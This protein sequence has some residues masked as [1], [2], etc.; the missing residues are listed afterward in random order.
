MVQSNVKWDI[1]REGLAKSPSG[2]EFLAEWRRFMKVHG[3]HCRGEVEF[4]NKRWSETPDYILGIL[5]G[6]INSTEKADLL[7]NRRRIAEQREQ[8]EKEC[9][10]R[11]KNPV[12]RAV[13]KHLLA[14]AQYG[15]V[16]R[17]NFKSE[18]I[19]LLASVRSILLELGQKLAARSLIA[20]SDDVFFLKLEELGQLAHSRTEE[21][22]IRQIIAARRADYEKWQSISPPSVIFGRFNSD[23][24]IPAE[25][26][27]GAELLYGLA[28]SPG[29]ASGRAR[30]IL[31]SD[32]GEQVQ[33]GEILI[34]PFTDPGWTPYFI[35]ATGIVME[36][37]GLLSHGA[38]IA[39][40][41]GI[42][43]V[44]NVGNATK[45]IKTGQTIQIDGNK[46]VVRLS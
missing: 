27:A 28:V 4:Y 38:V 39:R 7:E 10:Q 11:L 5:R 34:A 15:S 40:E 36:Q 16:F 9:R 31:R 20:D 26:N 13:F 30:V 12:K 14:R 33:A 32:S 37:G 6:F 44:V 1:V 23:T 29:V 17:E 19:K 18:V 41:Y 24:Y 42:P 2:G 45:I 8:L 43:A 35:P 3:H 46:G 25:V 21:V 22:D